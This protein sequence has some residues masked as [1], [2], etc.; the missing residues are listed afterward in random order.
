[1]DNQNIQPPKLNKR[2]N[3]SNK[4]MIAILVIVLSGG[5]G[6][7]G[8]LLANHFT[9]SDGITVQQNNAGFDGTI[10][11]ID[12]S[13]VVK[14][15][16]PTVVEIQTETASSGNNPFQQYVMQGAGSGVIVAENGYIVT[17]HHVIDGAT[18]IN[19]ITTSGKEYEGKVIGSDAQ[20]DLAI[21]KIEDKNLPY[22]TL[23][24][25]TKLNVGD[26]S[27]AIGNPL[28]SL[29]GTVT[30]GIISAL[31][32]EITIEG[33]TMTLLQTDAAINPGNSGG[34]L[35][36]AKGNLIGIVNAKQ[37]AAG[38]EGLGFAIPI[39]DALP[40]LDD[41]AKNG[42]VTSRP[43]LNLSLTDITNANSSLLEP[44]VY[45]VQIVPGGAADEAGLKKADRILTFDGQEITSSTEVKSI[46]RKHKIGDKIEIVVDRN[47]DKITKTVTLKEANF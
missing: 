20:T 36:D 10:E 41:L 29:G 6:F 37:S 22:A 15:C 43:A 9:H 32:R 34:G 27:I 16:L 5:C 33:E 3:N 21:V 39:S 17:N 24:D 14:S 46:L 18:S 25:S 45:I 42:H 19:V 23:G 12:V 13:D 30:T 2:K 40:I 35:F 38:I 1:M 44:G 7:A 26:T 31:N 4:W 28:G 8:S 11:A 47:G